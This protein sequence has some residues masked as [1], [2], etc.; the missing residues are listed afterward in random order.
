MIIYFLAYIIAF[1][2]IFWFLKHKPL[3]V[4][5]LPKLFINKMGIYFNSKDVHKIFI[6]NAK[7]I[8][9]DNKIYLKYD[10]EL[11]TIINIK[12]IKVE[13]K[14]LFFKADGNVKILLN[15]AKIYRYFNLI[16]LSKKVN[17][18]KFKQAALHELVNNLNNL[19]QCKK[20]KAYISFLNNVLKINVLHDKLTISKNL[21][22]FNYEL[23]YKINNI[24]KH[25]K[26]Y[27][28]I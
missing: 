16:V 24:V 27:Q 14:V 11:I 12:I 15:V 1:S 18:E 19:L 28:K 17:I 6:G 25:V 3:K 8:T 2:V 23:F 5:P 4:L 20:V 21:I 10:T 7:T 26:V 9:F 13:D 22:Y